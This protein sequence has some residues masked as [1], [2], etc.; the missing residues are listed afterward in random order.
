MV[1][2]QIEITLRS[3]L[4]AAS[5]DG[6]AGVLDSDIVFDALGLPYIPAKRIK[7]CLR[8][9]ALDILSVSDEYEKAYETL[10]GKTGDIRSGGIKLGN[11]FLKDYDTIASELKTKGTHMNEAM[12]LHTQIRV[13]TRMED[14]KSADGS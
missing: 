12:N 6:F 11:G 1:N 9:A 5:G 7:G 10:F 13:R 8:E 14:G 2:R 4:C 3:E